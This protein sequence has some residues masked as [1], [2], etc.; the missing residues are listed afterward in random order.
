VG[1]ASEQ[2]IHFGEDPLDD[3]V[4]LFDGG[5]SLSKAKLMSGDDPVIGHQWED[6]V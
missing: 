1:L 6:T 4:G 5:M 2:P 3:T